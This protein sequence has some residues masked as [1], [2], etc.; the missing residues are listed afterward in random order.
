ML[1]LK[2]TQTTHAGCHTAATAVAAAAVAC[3][4][5]GVSSGVSS[6]GCVSSGGGGGGSVS[7]SGGVSRSGGVS[8]GGAAA[9]PACRCFIKLTSIDV[10]AIL[11][12]Q[13]F[14]PVLSRCRKLN[15]RNRDFFSFSQILQ[16]PMWERGRQHVL[17]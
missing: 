12:P 11:F 14:P 6:S 2:H 3:A 15:V 4:R 10:K 5:S 8:S 7:S 13:G 17:G 9:I 1:A 16:S